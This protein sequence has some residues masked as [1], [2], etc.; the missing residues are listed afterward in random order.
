M[1]VKKGPNLNIAGFNSDCC[2]PRVRF[3]DNSLIIISKR[4][5]EITISDKGCRFFK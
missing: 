2:I 4:A 1:P 5:S 3:H